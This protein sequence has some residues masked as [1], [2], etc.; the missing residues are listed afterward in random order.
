MHCCIKHQMQ[1]CLNMRITR[2]R[3]IYGVNIS[4]KKYNSTARLAFV[5]SLKSLY[6][7]YE[8]NMDNQN[9]IPVRLFE[10][11]KQIQIFKHNLKVV[12]HRKYKWHQILKINTAKG[13]KDIL[14][15]FIL[16]EEHSLKGA[17]I[18]LT[19]NEKVVMLNIFV[20]L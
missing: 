8:K 14:T 5:L 13:V 20:T 18:K 10:S 12:M 15:N 11:A 9:K 16:M 4:T 3:I 7:I 6:K 2:I 17:H 1:N 19:P